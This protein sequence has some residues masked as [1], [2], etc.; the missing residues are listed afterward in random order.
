MPQLVDIKTPAEIRDYGVNWEVH[1]SFTRTAGVSIAP[2]TSTWVV[3]PAGELTVDA[4]SIEGFLTLVRV[5]GG[6]LGRDY[7][8]LNTILTNTGEKLEEVLMISVRTAAQRIGV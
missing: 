8:V 6:V 7:L 1:P 4:E 2:G 3:E 5:S